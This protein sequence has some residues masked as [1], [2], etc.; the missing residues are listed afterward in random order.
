MSEAVITDS[1]NIKVEPG[2]LSPTQKK[3]KKPRRVIYAGEHQNLDP[4][5]ARDIITLYIFCQLGYSPIRH[6][7][8]LPNDKKIEDVIRQHMLGR[9][10]VDGT[11]GELACPGNTQLDTL[12]TKVV[13]KIADKYG[14]LEE[15]YVYNMLV[16][17]RWSD[18]PIS[19][20]YGKCECGYKLEDYM[21]YCPMCGKRVLKSKQRSLV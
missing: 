7:L 11:I 5:I 8:D 21:V 2:Q 16:T 17:G 6:V 20:D 3:V 19:S 10:K 12:K 9:T 13:R 15:P 18:D 4:S 14:T 1:Y